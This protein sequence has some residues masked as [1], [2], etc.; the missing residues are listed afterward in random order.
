MSLIIYQTAKLIHSKFPGHLSSFPNYK[1]R[2][3]CQKP[4]FYS[5]DPNAEKKMR[6]LVYEMETEILM[7]RLKAEII[8]KRIPNHS[9][10]IRTRILR[11]FAGVQ[12]CNILPMIITISQ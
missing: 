7:F 3:G 9:N 6:A 2:I 10:Y 5:Y 1:E 11:V 12:Q 8:W 4:F